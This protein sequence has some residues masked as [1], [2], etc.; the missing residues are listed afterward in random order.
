MSDG[1]T[2]VLERREPS[3]VPVQQSSVSVQGQG[4]LPPNLE[5]SFSVN[6]CCGTVLASAGPF[7]MA[8]CGYI[9]QTYDNLSFHERLLSDLVS[10]LENP[11]S[12]Q[13]FLQKDALARHKAAAI[14][15]SYRED[16]NFNRAAWAVT[17]K[18]GG[19]LQT[20]PF[21]QVNMDYRKNSLRYWGEIMPQIL[22]A[23]CVKMSLEESSSIAAKAAS[24]GVKSASFLQRAVRAVRC[25]LPSRPQE[26]LALPQGRQAGPRGTS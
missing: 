4:E 13:P 12:M 15:L 26:R 23:C 6:T 18:R 21:C 24:F 1:I 20:H 17:V 3:S 16:H 8:V 11:G 25:L 7:S 19:S 10:F 2:E 9:V 5:Y 14:Q 22:T